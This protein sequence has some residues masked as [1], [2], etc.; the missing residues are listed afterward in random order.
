MTTNCLGFYA[1][2]YKGS[3]LGGSGAATSGHLVPLILGGDGNTVDDS[4]PA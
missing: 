4:D 3:L 1:T 2:N